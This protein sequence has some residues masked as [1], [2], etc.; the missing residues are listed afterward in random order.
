M[1][2]SS[3]LIFMNSMLRFTSI[4]FTASRHFSYLFETRVLMALVT[5]VDRLW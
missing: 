5:T 4:F 1:L 3:M 2:H